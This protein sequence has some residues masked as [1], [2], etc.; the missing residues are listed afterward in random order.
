M[1]WSPS[2][3]S[4]LLGILAMGV[5][6]VLY[7]WSEVIDW[8]AEEVA[9]VESLRHFG[10]SCERFV[11]GRERAKPRIR[12][13]PDPNA[14]TD[15]RMD[16]FGAYNFAGREVNLPAPHAQAVTNLQYLGQK[17]FML[18]VDQYDFSL[19]DRR[20]H[21]FIAKTLTL[22]T[23]GCGF[24]RTA[25]RHDF[26]EAIAGGA[27]LEDN[28]DERFAW[29]MA[30]RD[31]A[32]GDRPQIMRDVFCQNILPNAALARRVTNDI[33][34]AEWIAEDSSRGQLELV[35]SKNTIWSVASGDLNDVRRSV[36]AAG[37]LPFRASH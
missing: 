28:A 11:Y 17:L 3:V 23:G 8:Q 36:R 26:P 29:R 2:A 32:E 30:R 25:G 14:W 10:L 6:F 19:Q 24:A 1:W 5:L 21:S 33:S 27:S 7:D 15:E 35:G 18:F 12:K 22:K 31:A 9:C 4:H 20:L 34:L 37:L 13:T 16:F